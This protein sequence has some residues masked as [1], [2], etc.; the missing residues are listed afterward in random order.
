LNENWTEKYRPKT[1][2]EILGNDKAISLLRAWADEWEKGITPVKKAVILSGK[3]GIGKTSTALALANEYGWPVIELNASDV[4]NA[5]KIKSIVVSGVTNETFSAEGKFLSSNVGGRKLVILDEADNLYERSE[6]GEEKSSEEYIDKGGKRAIIE[7]IKIAKQPVILIVNDYYSLTRGTGSLL[8]DLCLTIKFYSVSSYQITNLLKEICRKEGISVHPGVLKIIADK[9][10]GDVRSAINDLQSICIGKRIVD[11]KDVDAI[12]FRDR[13]QEIFETLREIFK[14]KSLESIRKKM[15]NLNES[16]DDFIWWLDE[17][18]PYEYHEPADLAKAYDYLSK[19][20]LFL[21]RIY[22]RQ[23]F[24]LM[25]YASDLM[26]GGLVLTKS[27]HYYNVNYSFPSWMSEMK[28]SKQNREIRDNLSKKI[29]KLLHVSHNKVIESIFP[30]Y[31]HLFKTNDRFAIEMIKKLDLSEEEVLLLTDGSRKITE[32]L[33]EKTSYGKREE[34]DLIQI[35]EEDKEEL[36]E[37]KKQL[38]LIDF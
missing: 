34:K 23:Q 5:S 29:G 28:K 32:K 22:K 14:T 2:N 16:P 37:Q 38:K 20:D 12:G 7:A 36:E 11:L 9:S 24:D 19:A 33:L 17:N 18:I 4:R 25:S 30:Y 31:K 13:E 3:P 26:C 21:G 35:T 10:D 8:K 15:I 1:L 6:K 27:R